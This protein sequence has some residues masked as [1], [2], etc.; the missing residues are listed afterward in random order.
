MEAMNKQEVQQETQKPEEVKSEIKKMSY[1]WVELSADNKLTQKEL[2]TIE[3]L[4]NTDLKEI[5]KET[6][7]SLDSLKKVV[8]EDLKSRNERSPNKYISS[9]IEKTEKHLQTT[10]T[11]KTKKWDEVEN[12]SI[13][14]NL[15][16][17][18]ITKVTETVINTQDELD[19]LDENTAEETDK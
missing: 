5:Q 4:L 17:N 15:D 2:K 16:N 18:T 19:K 3:N 9:L 12:N 11:P 10:E 14:E 13:Q 1:K 7:W 6:K 8:L